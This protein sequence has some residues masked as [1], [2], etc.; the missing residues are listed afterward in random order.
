MSDLQ[1]LLAAGDTFEF[2]CMLNIR[3]CMPNAIVL[4]DLRL[5]STYLGKET[6]VDLVAVD[7]S[8]VFVIEAKNWKY[9]IRGNLDDRQWTGLSSDRKVMTVFNPYEQNLIHI[10]ALRNAIRKKGIEPVVFHNI[11][12]LPDGTEI[13]SDCGDVV[14]SSQ[15]SKLV[16]RMQKNTNISLNKKAYVELI[17]GVTCN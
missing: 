1:K 16:T 4:H 17:R 10:R 3:K 8:G 5:H 6:Q 14:N 12:V 11:V 15:I 9:W 2:R 7:D 13:H